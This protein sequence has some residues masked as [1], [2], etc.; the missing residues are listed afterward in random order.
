MIRHILKI[1]FMFILMLCIHTSS[2]QP[3]GGGSGDGGDP[4]AVPI[5]GLEIL[6]IAGAAL[7]VRKFMS[8][9]KKE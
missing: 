4:D 9:N 3:G 1:L 7:G 6:L 5:G 8:N 2:A